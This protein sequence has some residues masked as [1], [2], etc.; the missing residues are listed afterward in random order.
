MAVL[1]APTKIEYTV[2]PPDEFYEATVTA[3]SVVDNPFYNSA[4]DPAHKAHQF[5]WTFTLREPGYEGVSVRAFTSTKLSRHPK[6]VL[7]KWIAA[8]DDTFD[9]DKGYDTDSLVGKTC[10]ILAGNTTKEKDGETKTY[11][12]VLNVAVSKLPK[13][14]DAEVAKLTTAAVDSLGGE[15]I[16]F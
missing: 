6:A 16:P 7:P 5:E 4:E 8:C 11:N 10:R 12:K 15:E 2:L 1:E 14:S 3:L 13:L 9:I